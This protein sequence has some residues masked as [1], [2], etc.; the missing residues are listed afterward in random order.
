MAEGDGD[1]TSSTRGQMRAAPGWTSAIF[2]IELMLQLAFATRRL[3]KHTVWFPSGE[4]WLSNEGSCGKRGLHSRPRVAL[5]PVRALVSI[6][7]ARSHWHRQAARR[8]LTMC[9]VGGLFDDG[10][11]E[12]RAHMSVAVQHVGAAYVN[13]SSCPHAWLRE[14]SRQSWQCS[15]DSPTPTF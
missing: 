5:C 14:S 13:A 11:V 8:V 3:S 15:S 9:I 1:A 2:G 4:A 7:L 12:R 10:G 6:S